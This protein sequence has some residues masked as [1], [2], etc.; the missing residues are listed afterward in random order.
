MSFYCERLH[1]KLGNLVCSLRLSP[2]FIQITRLAYRS[3]TPAPTLVGESNSETGREPKT[4]P[5]NHRH[6]V[7]AFWK[8]NTQAPQPSD[9]WSRRLDKHTQTASWFRAQDSPTVNRLHHDFLIPS[10]LESVDERAIISTPAQHTETPP[11]NKRKVYIQHPTLSTLPLPTNRTWDGEGGGLQ[12]CSATVDRFSFCSKDILSVIE[13]LFTTP[14][15]G[16]DRA[17]TRFAAAAEAAA[18]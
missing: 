10:L 8:T 4:R 17:P 16:K 3:S 12:W 7:K 18:R 14:R 13:A 9:T 1:T 2:M 11:D 15:K 6:A 5:L